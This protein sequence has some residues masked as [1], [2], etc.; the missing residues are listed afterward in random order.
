MKKK[1][2]N[3]KLF[4]NKEKISNLK[5][6]K[7]GGYPPTGSNWICCATGYPGSAISGCVCC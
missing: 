4:L 1:I 3:K 6:I 7:G 5:D 2:L